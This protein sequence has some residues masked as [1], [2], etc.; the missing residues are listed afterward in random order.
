MIINTDAADATVE[1][2]IITITLDNENVYKFRLKEL[3]II[4][5][6]GIIEHVSMSLNEFRASWALGVFT[7]SMLKGTL[8]LNSKYK[9]R[10]K[11][12]K[13]LN[14]FRSVSGLI[15]DSVA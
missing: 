6:L 4:W 3:L 9:K 8:I 10:G 13:Y 11:V 12:D 14:A 1:N 7:L 15:N 5:D 2:V